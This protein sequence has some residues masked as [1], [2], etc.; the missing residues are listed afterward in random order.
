MK[1]ICIKQR[2]LC[3]LLKYVTCLS[4]DNTETHFVVFCEIYNVQLWH[5]CRLSNLAFQYWHC[6]GRRISVLLI[7]K[8][9]WRLNYWANQRNCWKWVCRHWHMQYKIISTLSHS[10][11]S[12]LVFIRWPHSNK[13]IYNNLFLLLLLI[14][15]SG[16][17][18]T[19]SCLYC[20]IHGCHS[21]PTLVPHAMDV[22]FGIICR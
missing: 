11:T 6:G 9:C 21:T 7:R 16:D 4:C 22:H 20:N 13:Y 5:I 3:F 18:T 19:Q 8:W 14:L 1:S 10:L 15:F 12:I 2:L 17:Y